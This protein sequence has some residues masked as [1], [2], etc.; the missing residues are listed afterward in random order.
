MSTNYIN[1]FTGGLVTAT[2]V[3]YSA[4]N[5]TQNTQLVWPTYAPTTLLNTAVVARNIDVTSSGNYTLGL[6]QANFGSLGDDIT[7]TNR[8]LQ[9]LTINDA[10]GNF[11]ASI[12]RGVSVWFY[13]TDNTTVSGIWGNKVLG[14]GTDPAAASNLAGKGLV[15]I[16]NQLNLGY[17]VTTVSSSS[18]T[19]TE[20]SRAQNIVWTGGLGTLG[21]PIGNTVSSGWFIAIR[22]QGTGTLTLDPLQVG[23][24]INGL[25][26]QPIEVGVSTYIVCDTTTGNY[27]AFGGTGAQNFSFSSATYDVDTI[28]GNTLNLTNGAPIIERFV[29]NSGTRTADLLVVLPAISQFYSVINATANTNYNINLQLSGSVLTPIVVKAN[30][31]AFVVSDGLALYLINSTAIASLQLN[32]GSPT[33]PTLNFIN[34]TNTGLYRGGS[35]QFGITVGG[36]SQLLVNASDPSAPV[37][38]TGATLVAKRISGGWI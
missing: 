2:I 18:F 38:T 25:S 29:A 23:A 9:A 1:P 4:L 6:P 7:I 37:I 21:L 12:A 14:A 19:F 32:D 31:Q 10:G 27:Y 17:P 36:N 13:I 30:T 11:I 15:A 28:L 26:N 33:A 8:S 34:E 5:L 3:S 16:N 35:R 22:N 24:T 20:S